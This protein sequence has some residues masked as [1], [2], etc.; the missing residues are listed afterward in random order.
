MEQWLEIRDQDTPPRQGGPADPRAVHLR[1]QL[2]DAKPG[3]RRLRVQCSR[4]Y[5]GRDGV[6]RDRS[7]VRP[8]RSL[9]HGPLERHRRN[10]RVGDHGQWQ[11]FPSVQPNRLRCL[12]VERTRLGHGRYSRDQ[13]DDHHR[14]AA[15]HRHGLPCANEFA[16]RAD[17]GRESA[18]G[19]VG[20]GGA[21][22]EHAGADPRHLQIKLSQGAGALAVAYRSPADCPEA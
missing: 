8:A 7:R 2:H 1:E 22:S 5:A 18:G 6:A 21:Q 17:A 16:D 9:R 15:V 4:D 10:R 14:T 11:L 3:R 19:R 20:H 13:P 12:V